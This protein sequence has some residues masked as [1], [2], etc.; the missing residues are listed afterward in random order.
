MPNWNVNEKPEN[1]MHVHKSLVIEEVTHQFKNHENLTP[2][3][4]NL[5]DSSHQLCESFQCGNSW[6]FINSKYKDWPVMYE[7]DMECKEWKS[8]KSLGEDQSNSWA[9]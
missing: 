2:R 5:S 8:S 1:L 3:S 4:A 9:T 7:L 6:F